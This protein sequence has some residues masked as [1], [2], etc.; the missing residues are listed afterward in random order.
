[1]I[2]KRA[3]LPAL[4]LA[5]LLLALFYTV[6]LAEPPQPDPQSLA[7]PPT[8]PFTTTVSGSGLIEANSRNI[9][10]GT[11][12]SGIVASIDVEV[13]AE[14]AKDTPLFRLDARAAQ[15]DA[16]VAERALI[17]AEATLG[18][19]RAALAEE[20]DQLRRAESLRP[21]ISV[22]TERLARQRL[23]VKTAEA[24]VKVQEAEQEKAKA[25]LAA[26]RV[27]LDR[28]VIKAPVTG[29][30]LQ[31]NI[32]PGEFVA[33][34]GD[35]TPPIILGNTTPLHVRVSIDENDLWRFTP[36]AKAEGAI[37]G[38]RAMTFPLKFIRL[39]PYV[40]PKYELTGS[41]AERVDTRVLDVIYELN[42][43]DKPVYVGQ[44][45]DVF[46]AADETR[47]QTTPV[48]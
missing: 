32:R 17:T 19:A 18:Q 10:V 48:P 47:A 40:I 5:G 46:I 3:L 45:I 43:G 2:N 22:S 33:A 27:T 12:L 25:A 23:V 1:M 4:G 14:I 9:A 36:A 28:L 7:E 15:A 21:G 34:S 42:P 11:P 29:R 20:E 39:E 16:A 26:A 41:S 6:F 8:S 24:R 30:I 38:N 35:Q 44:Q 31:I 37:R 13:G